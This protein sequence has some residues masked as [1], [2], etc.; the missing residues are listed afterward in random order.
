VLRIWLLRTHSSLKRPHEQQRS[1][2]TGRNGVVKTAKSLPQNAPILTE[3]FGPMW[4]ARELHKPDDQ[5]CT[6]DR[7]KRREAGAAWLKSLKLSTN[8][9]DGLIRK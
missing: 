6:G 1:G 2:S 3:V 8:P 5:E 4:L 9:N 7:S